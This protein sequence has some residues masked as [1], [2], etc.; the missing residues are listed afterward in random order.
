MKLTGAPK[1]LMWEK[2]AM[3]V[4]IILDGWGVD[5][6]GAGNAIWRAK[7]P[8]M[9]SLI[10]Q[11]PSTVLQAAGESVGL[12]WGEIGN[13]EVGHFA[14][15][16]GRLV[17]HNFLKINKAIWSGEFFKN[18]QLLNA[19]KRTKKHNS[20]LHFIGM[21][22]SGGVHSYIDHLFALLDMAKQQNLKKVYVH[23]ILDGRDTP[24]SS[25][26][27]FITQLDE[28]MKSLHIGTIATITGRYF[29]MD[30]DHH[31]ERTEAAYNTIV[32]ATSKNT[33][34]D[35]QKAISY[36]YKQKIYDEQIPP[37]NITRY[38]KPIIK[39]SDN[40]SVIFFNF[41]ADR[42]RQFVHSFV[43]TSFS[44]FN[45]ERALRN[46]YIT[47]FTHYDSQ[48]SFPVA[49][50]REKVLH[51]ISEVF[52]DA[53]W[54]QLHIAETEK[55]AHVTYFFNGG[56]EAAYLKEDHVL[57]PSL[58]V[59]HYETE[60]EMSAKKITK[61]VLN[62]I[63]NEKHRFI[64]INYANADMVGHT[65]NLRATITA[66]EFLDQQIGAIVE[67]TLLKSGVV[68]ITADH[69]NAE[70]LINIKTGQLQKEH[71]TNPVPF[72]IVKE[73][74]EGKTLGLPDSPDGDL[75]LITPSGL[76]SDVAP[77]ILH[78][79]GFKKPKEMTGRTLV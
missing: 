19:M 73:D 24:Y 36:F 27:Q 78:V 28:R 57:I 40:D 21:V 2:P 39:I 67:P 50:G 59:S 33:F 55:Y 76:L 7:T 64:A 69:G 43:D 56:K 41:R 15:G 5:Q 34:S 16:T 60:P 72:I 20:S 48:F 13:S 8:Y 52:S 63:V 38:N 45:R 62:S 79:C 30:R 54:S 61:R 18:K 68:F 10:K 37:I 42:M 53:G 58:P 4:L 9:D 22:S 74:F 70:S 17:Y 71:S 6:P 32:H 51:T 3:A 26:L 35:P 25:G 23:C 31:W 47:S 46:I 44:K 65:A 29:A 75:S 11:Y 66:L 49:W 12:P 77:T 14:I 1:S